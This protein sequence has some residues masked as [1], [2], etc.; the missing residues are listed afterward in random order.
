MVSISTGSPLPPPLF[1]REIG[2]EREAE[3]YGKDKSDAGLMG[4]GNPLATVR[5]FR[6]KDWG[7]A[8]IIQSLHIQKHGNLCLA[9]ALLWGYIT[10]P[11]MSAI[12]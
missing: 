12:P 9:S 1:K 2:N 8:G 11:A 7:R 6:P 4:R 10:L 3:A 5:S